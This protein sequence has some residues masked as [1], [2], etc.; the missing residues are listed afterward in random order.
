MAFKKTFFGSQ[1]IETNVIVYK[2]AKAKI[3]K[4]Y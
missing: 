3:L 4:R 2:E 1:K